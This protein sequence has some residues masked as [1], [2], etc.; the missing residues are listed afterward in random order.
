MPKNDAPAPSQVCPGIRIHAIDIVQPP[1]IGISPIAD[2]EPH[3]TVVTAALMANSNA[4]TPKKTRWEVRSE[5]MC[6]EI[7]KA[8][9][10]RSQEPE[11]RSQEDLA[12]VG[13]RFLAGSPIRPFAVSPCRRVAV[14]PCRRVAA[15]PRRPLAHS[16][17]PRDAHSLD[18]RLVYS[19]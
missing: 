2:M 18:H 14:S 4:E 9:D 7:K 1:G 5:T 6:P 16:P 3:Q 12:Q 19:S 17:T 15:S 11:F 10:E 13:T 8:F